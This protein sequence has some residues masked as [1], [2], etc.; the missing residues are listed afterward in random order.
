MSTIEMGTTARAYREIQAEIKQLEEQ[1]EAL[2]QSMIREMD[3]RKVDELDAGGYKIRYTI[4]E[5]SRLDSAKLKA[6]HSDLYATY[7][8]SMVSTRFQIA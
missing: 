3:S 8:K 6:E 1:A 4:Y 7:S 5:S 2:K